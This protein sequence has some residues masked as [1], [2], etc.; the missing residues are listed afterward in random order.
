MHG[1]APEALANAT[2]DEPTAESL[3]YLFFSGSLA[4]QDKGREFI[5]RIFTRAED[6][7]APT[8]LAVRDAQLDAFNAWGIA[9]AGKLTR[10]TNIAQPA[11]VANGDHDIMIPTRNSHLLGGFLPDA[12]VTIYP[13]AGHRFLFQY[14]EQFA[15]Q[16]LAFLA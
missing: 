5:A 12:T 15:A 11:L 1:L 16:V 2:L 8:S 10:L 6:R 13:D 4:S 7:D 14:A 3:L 9:D